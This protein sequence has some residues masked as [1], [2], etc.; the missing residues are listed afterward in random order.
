MN[1]ISLEK[2]FADTPREI[3][4]REGFTDFAKYD[5]AL[6]IGFGQTIS[7]P[8]TV[9][10][11]LEWLQPE[12]G[13]TI[14][15]IGS[16]SGWTSALLSKLVGERGRIIATEL[17][18]ELKQ[19]GKDNCAKLG[20]TNIEFH[21]TPHQIGYPKKAPYDRILVSASANKLPVELIEQLVD[22]GIM[23]IPIGDSIWVI[24][25]QKSKITKTEHPGYV[26]VPFITPRKNT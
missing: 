16:G 9:Y 18:P 13:D 11:M 8:S 23:V 4:V 24:E 14:L 25:K 12:Q 7:Q 3:F 1:R 19:F 10:N 26:F 22:D 6:P 21:H 15:D 2:A 17:I 5:E 20:L